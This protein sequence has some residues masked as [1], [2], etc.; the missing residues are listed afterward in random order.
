S[1]TKSTPWAPTPAPGARQDGYQAP[2]DDAEL[3]ICAVCSLASK[4][5]CIRA[6]RKLIIPA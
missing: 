4:A 1:R 5:D 6:S 2:M 3:E